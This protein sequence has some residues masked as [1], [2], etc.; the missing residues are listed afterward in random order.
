MLKRK[1]DFS[2][3]KMET[4]FQT[5]GEISD[6]KSYKLKKEQYLEFL[7]K[8]LNKLAKKQDN[9]L[10][11][12][13]ELLVQNANKLIEEHNN[14]IVIYLKEGQNEGK[15]V[16]IDGNNEEEVDKL[17]EMLIKRQML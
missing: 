15:T 2:Y 16:Q 3:T 7:D 5:I 10:I 9:Y 13:D 11:D 12:I 1:I 14:T 6:K 4:L 8:F 17:I